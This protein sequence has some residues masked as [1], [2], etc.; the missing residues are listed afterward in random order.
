IWQPGGVVLSPKLAPE[1][2]CQSAIYRKVG[3]RLKHGCVWRACALG[4]SGMAY[5]RLCGL[6]VQL[7]RNIARPCIFPCNCHRKIAR[8]CDIIA[9]VCASWLLEHGCV[10]VLN[11]NVFFVILPRV[12]SFFMHLF[13]QAPAITNFYPELVN[14]YIRHK[15][16]QTC[17][18]RTY[19]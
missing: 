2:V 1:C 11:T 18:H 5:A 12:F 15:N 9:R 3:T 6:L 7:S 17:Y 4:F 14:S 10:S 13:L 16:Y 19:L 8:S